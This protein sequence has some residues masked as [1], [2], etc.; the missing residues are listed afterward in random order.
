MC[1]SEITF[2]T[3]PE[4][5]DYECESG[6]SRNFEAWRDP[7]APPDASTDHTLSG[8]DKADAIAT[9]ESRTMESKLEMDIL[10]ALDEIKA[11]NQRHERVDTDKL[12]EKL[13]QN[14]RVVGQVASDGQ[15]LLEEE[16]K[17]LE[18]FYAS[19]RL[20]RIDDDDDESKSL[21]GVQDVVN[22][23]TKVNGKSKDITEAKREP[24]VSMG[25]KAEANNPAAK[26]TVTQSN[27]AKI[28]FVKRKKPTE[29]NG[30]QDNAKKS[31]PSP[32]TAP[33][34]TAVASALPL[35]AYASSS[36][37]EDR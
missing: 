9:L 33:S 19:R 30:I 8:D 17:A 4:H 10:D 37:D 6:A 34:T 24:D 1:N 29:S 35:N 13:D 3:D 21:N 27:K 28:T 15:E 2:K 18:Q 32:A 12:L 11:I 14:R 23:P 7:S 31:K 26:P 22:K 25:K 20:R 16:A 36:D 5:G